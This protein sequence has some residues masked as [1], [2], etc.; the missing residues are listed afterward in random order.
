MNKDRG[1]ISYYIVVF[2]FLCLTL[3][4]IIWLVSM[5]LTEETELLAKNTDIFPKKIFM[6]NYQKL[7]DFNTKE[8][9]TLFQGLKN[10]VISSGF[11]LL[12]GLPS[13]VLTAYAFTR[14]RFKGRKILILGLLISITI[15]VFTTLIPIYSMFAALGILDNLFYISVIY[16]SSLLPVNAWMMM[17]YY[18]NIPQDIWEAATIDGCDEKKLFLKVALPISKPII[19]TSGLMI[20]LM[21]W[22]QFQIPLILT[23]SQKN[24]VVTLIL[25][26]FITRDT[27][28]YGIIAACGV[29]TVLPPALLAIIFRKL[30]VDG[31][32]Q[33]SVKG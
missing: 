20:I 11:T 16:V 22:S 28:S 27:I 12:I 1:R 23:S 24:K 31:M 29:I 13:S 9:K 33:G 15:P 21:S 30:L 25:S 4:P 6:G 2:I 18:K 5:S 32:V 10:S 17:N 14:Y 19:I 26:E 7:L 3:A 8:S